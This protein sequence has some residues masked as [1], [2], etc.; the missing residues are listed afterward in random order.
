MSDP[1]PST[2]N[3]SNIRIAGVGGLGMVIVAAVVA[4]A[5]PDLRWFVLIGV[6]GGLVGGA[7]YVAYRRRR[8]PL[9][10]DKKPKSSLHHL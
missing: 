8:G 10:W 3:I 6:V 7:S 5:V 4:Y 9:D 1:N 2:I